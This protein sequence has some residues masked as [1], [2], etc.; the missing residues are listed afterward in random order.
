MVRGARK[1]N[2]YAGV[3]VL[4]HSFPIVLFVWLILLKEV[5]EDIFGSQWEEL[6][7]RLFKWTKRSHVAVGLFSIIS[8]MTSKCV[9]NKKVAFMRSWECH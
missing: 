1:G 8:Q 3:R 2:D 7:P 5:I 9:K 4:L 6:I